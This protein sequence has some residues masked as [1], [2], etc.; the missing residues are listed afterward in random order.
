MRAEN[1]K[2]SC[3]LQIKYM[4]NEAIY[5]EKYKNCL[6]NIYQDLDYSDSDMYN[7]DT[8]V[9]LFNYHRDFEV[10]RGYY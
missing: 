3:P 10:K 9:F 1:S 6:I 5:T 4:E 8:E 7:E 2:L